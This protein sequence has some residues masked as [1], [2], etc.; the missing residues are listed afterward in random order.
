VLGFTRERGLWVLTERACAWY[1]EASARW[2]DFTNAVP[3]LPGEPREIGWIGDA[4]V[5][6]GRGRAAYALR[7][8]EGNPAL[9]AFRARAI[10]AGGPEG[11]LGPDGLPGDAPESE[12][13]AAGV[14]VAEGGARRRFTL[15]EAGLGYRHSA[16]GA[17]TLKGGA[18]V[19]VEDD[20]SRSA[21]ESAFDHLIADTRVDLA[22]HGR[23]GA[24][25]SL[26]GLYDTTDPNNAAYLLHYRGGRDDR[27]RAAAAGEVDPQQFETELAPLAG[28][29]GGWLR[30]EGGRRTAD[31]GRRLATGDVWAG[32]RRVYPGREVFHGRRTVYRLAHRHLVPDSE[33]IRLDRELL[34]AA[35][36]YTIDW[37]QGSFTLAE[38]LLLDDDASIEAAYL[39]EIA[40]DASPAAIDTSLSPDRLL[41]AGAVGL[42]P[43]DRL[44]LG[45]TGAS[46]SPSGESRARSLGA[47]ARYEARGEQSFLRVIPEVAAGGAD[48]T[49]LAA[50]VALRAR[51][52]GL[53]LTGRVRRMGAGFA[54]LE[55]RRTRL[56]RLSGD[57]RLS[58]RWDLAPQWQA[59]VDW[60]ETR[61]LLPADSSGRGGGQGREAL[62]GGTLRFLGRNLPQVSLRQTVVR[63]DSLDVRQ[64]KHVRR[65]EIEYA[66]GRLRLAGGRIQRLWLRAFFQRSRR[67]TPGTA[68]SFGNTVRA[69]DQG[70]LRLNGSAGNPLSW[71]LAW[72]E[73]WSY[74]PQ[75]RGAHGLARGQAVDVT[76]QSRP[77][78]VVDAYLRG[79][80]RRD[81]RWLERG[82]AGGF[83]VSR[84]LLS[85]TQLYPGY[86]D[87]RLRPLSLRADYE[88]SSGE[89]GLAGE[90]LP[91][92]SRLARRADEASLRRGRRAAAIETR[93]QIAS[94]LRW[95]DLVR[96]ERSDD[97]SERPAETHLSSAAE[98]RNR[99][100]ENRLELRA[101]GG[102]ITLRVVTERRR[103]ASEQDTTG[104]GEAAG[105]GL[106]APARVES[107]LRVLRLAGEWS[108]TWGAGLLTYGAL[109]TRRARDLRPQPLREW[110]AQTRAQYRRGRGD[111][112][113]GAGLAYRVADSFLPAGGGT[114]VRRDRRTLALSLSF[115]VRLV[116][117]LA[118]KLQHQ[119]LFERAVETRHTVDLR[120]SIRA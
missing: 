104:L 24:E 70:F 72:D 68:D 113:A 80:A 34:R 112:D 23:M 25:R 13:G 42:S 120:L 79:E 115:S 57:S 65:A 105:A 16:Q 36:D 103:G 63:A 56:G 66:P 1:D 22:L 6:L 62:L 51:R 93:L 119:A 108:Q 117:V 118:L 35:V 91:G 95:I 20:A 116:R 47:A 15:D 4:L 61:S 10:L 19:Y 7:G 2:I 88:R 12:R 45:F 53:E 78:A 101:P 107:D 49:A 27:L 58:G 83:E 114:G 26:H 29:R 37:R 110:S 97:A 11:A 5:L 48:S 81:L 3:L 89:G 84:Q 102:L 85:S 77:H 41:Y 14:P 50:S 60:D 52:R 38:H 8:S 55:D 21:G 109:E 69:T 75:E 18:T 44:F 54:T 30:L 99:L 87:R 46:W 43:S 32:E 17:L 9:F 94:W 92:A 86:L 64:E 71:N 40:A 111:L 28:L 98:A 76:L 59:I 31:A 106:A 90:P 67:E 73:R 33:R 100:F 82:G 96:H 39:Y 74:R